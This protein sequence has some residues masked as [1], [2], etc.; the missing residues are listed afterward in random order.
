M[1]KSISFFLKFR[2]AGEKTSFLKMM[3]EETTSQSVQNPFFNEKAAFIKKNIDNMGI[4][5]KEWQEEFK[6]KHNRKPTLE[7]MQKD[8]QISGIIGS[9]KNEKKLL[10]STIQRFRIN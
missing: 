4:S 7:D 2:F 1:F 8:P 5:L 10:K 6:K 9:M 3:S